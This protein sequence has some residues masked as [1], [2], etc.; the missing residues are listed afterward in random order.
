MQQISIL[1]SGNSAYLFSGATFML[2][3]CTQ[4]G[5]TGT[6][7]KAPWRVQLQFYNRPGHERIFTF[8]EKTTPRLEV[9]AWWHIYNQN[10]VLDIKTTHI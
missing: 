8:N 5:R 4:V 9:Q 6:N 2:K 1:N 3:C 10:E 7:F